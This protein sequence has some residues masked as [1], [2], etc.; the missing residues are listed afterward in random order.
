MQGKSLAGFG[1]G[2]LGGC[3]RSRT[4][5]K[6]PFPPPTLQGKSLAGFGSGPLGGCLCSKPLLDTFIGTVESNSLAQAAGMTGSKA[7]QM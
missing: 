6:L 2:P 5:M 1:G 7:K 4:G 3:L